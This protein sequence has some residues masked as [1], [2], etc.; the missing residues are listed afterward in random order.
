MVK[1]GRKEGEL[2]FVSGHPG[3]TSRLNTVA[4]LRQLGET[5][6]PIILR[7]LERREAMLKKYM[8]LGEEQT[9]RAQN[10]LNSTQNSLKVYRGQLAGLKGST[11]MARKE[12]DE[13][14]LRDWAAANPDR[15]KNYG[16]AWDAIAKAH[17]TLPRY[18]RER[19][20]FDQAGGFNTTSFGIARTLVRLAEESQ[21]PNSERLPE[22]TDA[23][24]ASLELGLYSPAPI[25]QTLKS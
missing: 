19:K 24:R 25:A 14:A 4:H 7:L 16:D 9:R 5:S 23:R 15:K 2:V 13:K 18:I 12:A 17:Q 3:S 10:E 20:I 8:T 11:L 1:D 21:K 6:V 22:F